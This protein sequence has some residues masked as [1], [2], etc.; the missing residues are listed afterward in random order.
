MQVYEKP[1]RFAGGFNPPR[2]GYA[3]RLKRCEVTFVFSD[4]TTRDE[5]MNMLTQDG[6]ERELVAVLVDGEAY[7][8]TDP[9]EEWECDGGKV[10][11]IEMPGAR[12]E[13]V[14]E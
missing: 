3:P 12:Y 1:E 11:A 10:V 5:P 6:A 13:L 4:G 7:K 8:P 9:P 14:D 2:D